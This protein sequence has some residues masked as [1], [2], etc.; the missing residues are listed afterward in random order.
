MTD[1]QALRISQG[2]K[3]TVRGI[4]DGSY[5]LKTVTGDFLGIGRADGEIVKAEK[6]L[7]QF[8]VN[9]EMI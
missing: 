3:T 1:N 6:I 2:V 8:Q 7:K 5:R 4:A 9:A